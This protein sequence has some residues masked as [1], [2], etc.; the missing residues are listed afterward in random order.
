MKQGTIDK[1]PIFTRMSPHHSA[2]QTADVWENAF[3]NCSSRNEMAQAL[4]DLLDSGALQVGYRLPSIRTLQ[5]ISGLRQHDVYRALETLAGEGRIEQ[6]RGSGTFV[7]EMPNTLVH[8][9]SETLHIGVVP[10][11]WDPGISHHNVTMFLAGITEQ[12]GLRHTIQL[13]PSLVPE[14]NPMG[15]ANHVRSLRLDGIIWIKPPVAPPPALIA[16][17]AADIPVVVLGRTY[18]HLPIATADYDYDKM[19]EA[20]AEYLVKKRRKKLLCMVGVRNDQLMINQIGSLRAAMERR[21]MRLPEE[22]LVTVRVAAAAQMFAT[23][24]RESVE[25]FFRQHDDFDAVYSIYSDQFDVLSAIHENGFRRCPEDFIH[26]HQDASNVWSGQQ[27]PPFKT[28]MLTS[29][30]Q[31]VGRQAVKELER[32]LGINKDPEPE[33]LGP[34]IEFDPYE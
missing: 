32:I 13:V 5:E 4:R 34:R 29:P 18:A 11:S 3:Q 31:P 24:L 15:F 6:R 14:Q 25:R 10:P 8:Q 22:Q 2:G 1:A 26:I 12:A 21:G 17:L 19:G 20:I 7:L 16:L 27:W 30:V 28:A 33:N 9:R 23:D